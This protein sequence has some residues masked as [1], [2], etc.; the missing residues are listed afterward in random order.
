MLSENITLLI[1]SFFKFLIYAGSSSVFTI[2]ILLISQFKVY[3]VF[4]KRQIKKM[5]KQIEKGSKLKFLLSW[6]FKFLAHE[7]G[8][9]IVETMHLK[10][11]GKLV[12]SWFFWTIWKVLVQKIF[13]NDSVYEW[14]PWGQMDKKEMQSRQFE[15]CFYAETQVT[16]I[17]T[18]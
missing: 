13:F 16:N 2:I 15:M 4:L 7:N 17:S 5:L 9:K 18:L 6:T 8:N 1:S 14:I 10:V 11:A 3:F 12:G